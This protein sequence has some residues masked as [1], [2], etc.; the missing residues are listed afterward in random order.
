MREAGRVV[1]V[2]TALLHPYVVH[3][4][5]PAQ[6]SLTLGPPYLRFPALAVAVDRQE[7]KP[8]GT[9]A[10]ETFTELTGVPVI[11]T[12]RM[13]EILEH[14]EAAGRLPAE[15]RERCLAYLEEYSTP[16]AKEWVAR[17]R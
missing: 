15:D 9:S 8:D 17:R 3:H 4:Q 12:L 10:I 13:T 5:S 1:S 2:R 6:G 16:Q 11:P 7:T 14:L